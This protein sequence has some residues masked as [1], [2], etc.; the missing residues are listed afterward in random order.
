MRKLTA[1][2]KYLFDTLGFVVIK[3]V[4]TPI[5]VY[6]VNAAIDRRVESDFCERTGAVRNSQNGSSGRLDCG[7]FLSWP[8]MDSGDVLRSILCHPS[9]HPILDELCGLGHRLDH[10]PILFIQRPAAEGFDL[11][12]GAVTETGDYNFPISY[13]CHSGRIV[14]N[15]INV[16]V[17]LSDTPRGAGGFVVVPGSHKSNFPFPRETDRLQ[18][19]ADN[20]GT[21]PVAEAGDV[22]L[23]SEA[24]LHGASVRRNDKDRRV[25]LIRFAPATCAYARGYLNHDFLDHLTPAQRAVCEFPYHCDQDRL[26]PVIPGQPDVHVPN[27]RKPV[28]KEFDRI[29][30]N[31]D[32]Y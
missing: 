19:L 23:F 6:E 8:V 29:V 28:K 9:L 12:G 4:L 27:P 10:K 30:F 1:E 31:N 26:V 14:C 24:V 2:E 3:K 18:W 13:H 16:A 17:Q 21:E 7:N 11:H 22:I 25:A 5:E 32:Y 15:L 20:Y